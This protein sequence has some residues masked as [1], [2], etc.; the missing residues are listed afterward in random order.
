MIRMRA[1]DHL[2]L[3]CRLILA[4][5]FLQRQRFVERRRRQGLRL[6]I[7]GPV[8][9]DFAAA[10]RSVLAQGIRFVWGQDRDYA[11]RINRQ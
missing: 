8:G 5:L 2:V 3:A 4:A 1:E 7:Q 6:H 9:S 10:M 11:S